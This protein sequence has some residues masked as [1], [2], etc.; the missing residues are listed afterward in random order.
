M[1]NYWEKGKDF[2]YTELHIL[3]GDES[4]VKK[5]I[6]GM[7]KNPATIKVEINGNHILTLNKVKNK[8]EYALV[9]N[10]Q[11]IYV[12]PVIQ[13]SDGFEDW[14]VASWNKEELMKLMKISVFSMKL[15]SVEKLKIADLF[16]PQLL[17]KLPKKQ[18]LAIELAIKENYYST[19]RKINFKK[20]SQISKVSPQTF[21]EN[22]AGAENKLVPFLVERLK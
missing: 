14:E 9:F 22:L 17:P 20:L 15:I 5:F 11:I 4:N 2:Y 8:T 3:Q 19:P 21:Q 13:R 1:L 16:L 7:K 18:K 10:P 12:K 6:A